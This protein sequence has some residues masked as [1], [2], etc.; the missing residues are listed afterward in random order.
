MIHFGDK[1]GKHAF[2]LFT[3][4]LEVFHYAPLAFGEDD[5]NGDGVLLTEAPATANRLIILLKA[6]GREVGNVATLL[7]VQTPCADLRFGDQNTG[8]AFSEVDQPL[9]FNVVTIRS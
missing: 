9:F 8:S 4:A 6:V 5:V 7:E 2:S 1:A 3:L